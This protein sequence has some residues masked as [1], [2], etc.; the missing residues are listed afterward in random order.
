MESQGENIHCE[1][2]FVKE[3]FMEEVVGIMFDFA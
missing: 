2:C 1:M 3:G